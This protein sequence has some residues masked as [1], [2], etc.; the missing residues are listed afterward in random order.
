MWNGWGPGTGRGL[1]L[2]HSLDLLRE[3]LGNF[4][5]MPGFQLLMF[6][7]RQLLGYRPEMTGPGPLPRA[8][9]AVA[10]APG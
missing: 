7:I 9:H 4:H 3:R 2:A 5:R 8:T 10:P 6:L 1:V